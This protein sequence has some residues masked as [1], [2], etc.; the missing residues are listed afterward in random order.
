MTQ[1]H[2]QGNVDD[3]V[4]IAIREPDTESVIDDLHQHQAVVFVHVDAELPTTAVDDGVISPSGT[5]SASATSTATG[6]FNHQSRAAIA[7]TM[8][9]AAFDRRIENFVLGV[10]ST[11]V[12]IGTSH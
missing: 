11:S 4:A 8:S 2:G 7:T 10:D 6:E 5:T 12:V 3:V 1:R 9:V